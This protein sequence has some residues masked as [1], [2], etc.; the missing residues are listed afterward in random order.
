[1]DSSG[2]G[3]P[4]EPTNSVEN[5]ESGLIDFMK[6]WIEEHGVALEMKVAGAFRSRTGNGLS[7][8]SVDHGRTYISIDPSSGAQ[9]IREI[10]VVVKRTKITMGDVWITVW[11]IIEC[12]SSKAY[13]WVLYR[14]SAQFTGHRYD[15]FGS[16]WGLKFDENVNPLNI[17]G[18]SSSEILA[19]YGVV[20]CYSVTTAS[21][22]DNRGNQRNSF[23]EAVLQ[24]L[25][26]VKGVT[27]DALLDDYHKQI[28]VFIPIVVTSAP[29]FSITLALDGTY[30]ISETDRALFHGRIDS[31]NAEPNSVW[32]I[33]ESNLD[34]FA[35]EILTSLEFLEYRSF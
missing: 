11:L 21:P 9:K 2:I 22:T 19:G 20:S 8:S 32:V 3:V 5:T 34:Q 16:L 23:R 14:D 35:D 30:S 17:G 1:M 29:M 15:P 10:D 24:V 13:P 27:E 25:S 7:F 31:E 18:F 33:T 26:A 12:K 6:S 28:H 4:E